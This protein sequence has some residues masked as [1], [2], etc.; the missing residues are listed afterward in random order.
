MA[1]A[2]VLRTRAAACTSSFRTTNAPRSQDA[3]LP[4]TTAA[5]S[6]FAGPSAPAAEGARMAP[7][8]TSGSGRSQWRPRR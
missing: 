4:A 6:R 1:I 2:S 3:A 7:V 8:T 5:A